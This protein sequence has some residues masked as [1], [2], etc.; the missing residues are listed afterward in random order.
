MQVC[1]GVCANVAY[2]YICVCVCVWWPW[3]GN[4]LPW[5]VALDSKICS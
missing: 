2:I 1:L 3:D 4:T 5:S